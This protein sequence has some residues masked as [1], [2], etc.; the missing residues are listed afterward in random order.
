MKKRSRTAVFGE[1]LIIISLAGILFTVYPLLSVYL[2]PGKPIVISE[3]K[4]TKGYMVAIP[5]INAESAIITNVDPWDEAKY[6]NALQKGVAHAIGTSLP[7]AKGTSF[8]F[9]HSSGSP[10]ELTHTNT[11][12]LRLGELYNGDT[13]IISN[14]GKITS[15]TVYA[16]KEVWPN[17]TQY[18]QYKKENQVIL[19]TC[20]PIGT[21]LKRLLIFAKL[22][23]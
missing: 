7:G 10:W 3:L 16:K 11:L 20:T 22:T 17:D 23:R 1:I 14:N 15:Y 4:K 6:K 8:L 21:S 9:A 18:L 13:I 19:Q 2:F 12:F 5:K